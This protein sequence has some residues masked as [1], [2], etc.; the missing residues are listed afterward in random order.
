MPHT[1]DGALDNEFVTTLSKDHSMGTYE[2]RVGS[3]NKII[4]IELGRFLD[5]NFTKFWISHAIHTP[6][7]I[8]PYVGSRRFAD[9]PAYALDQAITGLTEYYR[10][11]VEKGHRP[12]ESWL[13]KI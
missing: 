3:L 6:E 10:I 2:I 13:V 12:A 11:A 4:T 1:L 9:C 7:Q 8:S 5:S